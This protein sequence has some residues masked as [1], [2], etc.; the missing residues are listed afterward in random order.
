MPFGETKGGPEHHA[1]EGERRQ[2]ALAYILNTG[3]A[4]TPEEAEQYLESLN[5][6]KERIVAVLPE[7]ISSSGGRSNLHSVTSEGPRP[8]SEPLEEVLR[9]EKL[10]RLNPRIW[11][12]SLRAAP[13]MMGSMI[14]F[15]DSLLLPLDDQRYI[16]IRS[17][18]SW[19]AA[20]LHNALSPEERELLY[21]EHA[22]T[23]KELVSKLREEAQKLE[24]R[25]EDHF[26]APLFG[27]PPESQEE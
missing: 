27:N 11:Q 2:K 5:R 19:F 9:S 7:V 22:L 23:R 17:G 13:A 21:Q 24:G 20:P 26:W 14:N 16:G 12:A 4:K 6:L 15:E 1:G 25:A 10:D 3:R 18:D 8:L